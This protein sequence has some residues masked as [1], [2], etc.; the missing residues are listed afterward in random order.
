M[1]NKKINATGIDYTN[2]TNDQTEFK[3][4]II[5]ETVKNKEDIT[6]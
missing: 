6:K 5:A 3:L 1:K 2:I 4:R